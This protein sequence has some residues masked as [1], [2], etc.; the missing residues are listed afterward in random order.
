MQCRQASTKRRRPLDGYSLLMIFVAL[1][2]PNS[3]F[4]LCLWAPLEWY[5]IESYLTKDVLG[6]IMSTAT[7]QALSNAGL[8]ILSE[9]EELFRASVR[10]FAEGEVRPRVEAMERASKLDPT[11]A[12]RNE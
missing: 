6:N 9:D 7:G 4:C 12:M 8:T 5:F 1:R 3:L 10:E 2:L 11:E